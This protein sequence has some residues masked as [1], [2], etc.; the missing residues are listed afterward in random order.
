MIE[1][2][3]TDFRAIPRSAYAMIAADPPWRY[4]ARGEGYEKSPQAHYSCMTTGQLARLDVADLAAPNCVLWLWAVGP[5]LD[6]A[7]E[8]M[9]AWGFR[10]VTA[11][12]WA[13]RTETGRCWAFGTGYTLRGCGEF[14]LIG[15]RG[16]PQALANNQRNFIAPEDLDGI[17]GDAVLVDRK[18]EHSRK[19]D[20]A[21]QVAEILFPGPRLELFSREPRP[22]WSVFGNEARK[23][24]GQS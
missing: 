13:K 17:L 9:R 5:L 24:E 4:E 2:I 20:S 11:G 18:R 8:L 21:Y 10:Y 14:F 6:Q 16:N 22:G 7:F 19:P 3:Y 23:F 12:T 1:G 15:K